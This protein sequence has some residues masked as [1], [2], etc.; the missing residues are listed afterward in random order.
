MLETHRLKIANTT[1]FFAC[2]QC[3]SDRK[4]L[5]F[6]NEAIRSF[7]EDQVEGP[8]GHECLIAVELRRQPASLP[9]A[10]QVEEGRTAERG[11]GP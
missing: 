6:L 3:F 7:T 5:L 4:H 9:V 8:E 10:E 2:L 1:V 11:D